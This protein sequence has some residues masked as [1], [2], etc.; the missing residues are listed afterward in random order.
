MKILE[1]AVVGR[2]RTWLAFGFGILFAVLFFLPIKDLVLFVLHP[3][4]RRY[5]SHIVFIPFV[6]GYLLYG[7]R[8]EVVEHESFSAG[9]GIPVLLG[10]LILYGIGRRGSIVSDSQTAISLQA[11]S[12]V[13]FLAGGFIA[14][15]GVA[16][17]RFA[18]FPFLFLLFVAPLPTGM[19]DGALHVLQVCSTEVSYLL[20]KISGIPIFRDGFIFSLPGLSI[21]VAKACSGMRSTITLFILT[22]LGGHLFLR[23]IR[24]KIVLALSTFPITIIGNSLRIVGLTMLGIYVDRAYIDGA[25]LPHL[26]GGWLFFLVD[27]AVAAGVAA[28]LKRGDKNG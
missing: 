19:M 28:A 25:S 24:R 11:V 10:A 16:A 12:A 14:I 9:V 7:K 23:S 1:Q 18:R 8:K 22:V 6:S 27:L 21:E 26:R 4:N 3:E 13:V 5:N 17:F 15:Y 2:P 20:F